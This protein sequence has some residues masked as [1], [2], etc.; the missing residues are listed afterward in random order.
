M[1]SN[2]RL[3]AAAGLAPGNGYSHAVVTGG[4]TAFVS[5]QVA[6]DEDGAV[7]GGPDVFA[8]TT[9][10]LRNLERVLDALGASWGDVARLGWYV[11]D[12]SRVQAVR[13]ARDAVLDPV[14]GDQPR[15]AS[16]LVQVAALF[17][18]DLVVEVDAVVSLPD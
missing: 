12:A 18:P 4:R 10:A 7:V 8:Q 14:L 1:L 16:T 15:P 3:T 5:G 13:D 17:R 6:L 9:Q 2:D 11:L